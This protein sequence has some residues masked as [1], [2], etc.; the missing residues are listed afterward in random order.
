MDK[1]YQNRIRKC[2]KIAFEMLEKHY[3]ADSLDDFRTA[4]D[5]FSEL[6]KDDE[7]LSEL[8]IAVYGELKRNWELRHKEIVK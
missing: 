8:L 6:A 5:E 7:L 3:R 1:G 4:F 2:F